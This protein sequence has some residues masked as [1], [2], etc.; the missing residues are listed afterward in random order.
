MPTR[1]KTKP[2]RAKII[3]ESA[4]VSPGRRIDAGQANLPERLKH[5][6][7]ER[8]MTLSALSEA[9][10]LSVSGLSK[11]E[12]GQMQLSYGNLVKLAEGLRVDI[13]ELFSRGGPKLV[14][15]MRSIAKAG[16]GVLY[17]DPAKHVVHHY[18]FTELS[19]KS[20]DVVVSELAAT[21]IEEHGGLRYH[22]GQEIYYVLGGAVWLH[23]DVYQPVNLLQGEA[24][25]IDGMMGH[26]LTVEKGQKAKVLSIVANMKQAEV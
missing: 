19:R 10:G 7:K 26:A 1:A 15:G 13:V 8:G 17:Q 14:A 9:T 12:N 23:T 21:T 4:P 16:V 22:E 20:M 11:V 24:V 6:R 3:T 5:L 2:A 25:Y 18:L